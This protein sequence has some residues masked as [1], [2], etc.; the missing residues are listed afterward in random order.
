AV[1]A[2][3]AT[4]RAALKWFAAALRDGDAERLRQVVLTT[5]PAEERMIAGIA[6]TARALAGLHAAASAAFGPDAAGRF[7]DDA[8]ADFDRT[9]ARIDA[10]DVAVDADAA[11]VR[12]PEDKDHPYPLKRVGTTWMVP[13]AHFTGGADPAALDRR[14]AELRVQTRIVADLTAEIAAGRYKNADAAGQAWR[15]KLMAAVGG[16]PDSK[17]ASRPATAPATRPAA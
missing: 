3:L 11:T 12:Y 5:R 2:S 10:A 4:P 7:A 13:A 9:S 15:S 8:A 1:P 6:D 17:P 14:L 16:G